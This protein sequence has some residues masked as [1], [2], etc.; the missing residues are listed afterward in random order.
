MKDDEFYN[1]GFDDD[2]D[3]DD[4]DWDDDFYENPPDLGPC[5]ACGKTGP[6]V[7]NIYAYSLLAPEPGKG[8]GCLVCGLPPDGALAVVCE[9]CHNS[10]AEVV[11]VC[12]GYPGDGDR[13]PKKS[14]SKV[15]FEH[16]M[17]R[18]PEAMPL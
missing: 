13:V 8:W 15:P 2:W 9:E 16:D 1:D 14:L 7:R 10:N 12:R 17:S 3:D 5:C 11:D 6:S 18:H 4:D